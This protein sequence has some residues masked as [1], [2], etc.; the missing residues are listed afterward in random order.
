MII[1]QWFSLVYDHISGRCLARDER[2]SV[3]A[4]VHNYTCSIPG[5]SVDG[6]NIIVNVIINM[7]INMIIN[8]I[9]IIM[10]HSCS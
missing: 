9:I 4:C 7:I 8:I 2:E 10:V 3:C 1:S 5:E 6:S